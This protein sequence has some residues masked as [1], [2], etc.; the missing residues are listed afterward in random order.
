[1]W[2][3]A[4]KELKSS[5]AMTTRIPCGWYVD[6][7]FSTDMSPAWLYDTLLDMRT[8]F[9][10]YVLAKWLALCN[11][12]KFSENT[13]GIETKKS[14][15]DTVRHEREIS[16]AGRKKMDFAERDECKPVLLKLSLAENLVKPLMS[17]FGTEWRE[18]G[19]G[20]WT[21]RDLSCSDLV[22]NVQWGL[23]KNLLSA[24]YFTKHCTENPI[25]VFPETAL[26]RSQFLHLCI[27]EGFI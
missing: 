18:R 27:C 23:C 24:E 22:R 13:K 20:L 4:W 26:P 2:S 11:K 19:Y 1:M 17:L 7:M 15:T 6:T 12:P 21:V 3:A 5:T 9:L 25:Y 14:V 16:N 10:K 8:E